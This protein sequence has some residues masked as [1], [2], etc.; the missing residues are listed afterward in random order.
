MGKIVIA[1]SLVSLAFAGAV[2][3]GD[4]GK[5]DAATEKFA[6]V[7]GAD[8]V[9]LLA[10]EMANIRGESNRLYV[11]SLAWTTTEVSPSDRMALALLR[12]GRST[13]SS[14]CCLVDGLAGS[15]LIIV[16][17]DGPLGD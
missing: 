4:I 15:F 7:S 8:A 1:A 9:P 17:N 2:H 12:A 13:D 5:S 6:A 3:A 10:S 14:G 16:N 11:G